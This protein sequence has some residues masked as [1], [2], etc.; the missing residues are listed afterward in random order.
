MNEEL[1][2]DELRLILKHEE[3]PQDVYSLN[4]YA[5]ESLCMEKVDKYWLVYGGDRGRRVDVQVFES[6]SQACQNF[7]ERITEYI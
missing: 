2:L 6:E 5:D 7:L 3:I 1:T 4:G